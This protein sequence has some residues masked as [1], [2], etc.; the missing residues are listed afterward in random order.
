MQV[1]ERALLPAVRTAPE[2]TLLLADGFSCRTQI[3]QGTGRRALHLAEAIRLS[4][5]AEPPGDAERWAR[6]RKPRAPAALRMARAA[7][8]AVAIAGVIA[9]SLWR[10]LSRPLP[11]WGRGGRIR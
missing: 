2:G 8:A 7:A 3:A 11:R 6:R 9:L 10:S 1:G 5:E 4:Q